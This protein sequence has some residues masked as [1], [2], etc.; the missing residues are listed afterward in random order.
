DPLT[1]DRL[2]PRLADFILGA[3]KV[4]R[5]RAD[6]WRVPTLLMFAGADELVDPR[7]SRGFVFSAPRYVLKAHEFAGA[8]HEI[9]NETEPTRGEALAMLREWLGTAVQ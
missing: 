1:H 7:G 5:Q 4:V 8:Y 9:F 6:K 3:G 2:T